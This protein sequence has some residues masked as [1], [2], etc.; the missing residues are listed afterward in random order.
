MADDGLQGFAIHAVPAAALE[1]HIQQQFL[2]H[3]APIPGHGHKRLV[4][5]QGALHAGMRTQI[6]LLYV[7]PEGFSSLSSQIVDFRNPVQIYAANSVSRE[8]C[9]GSPHTGGTG[10]SEEILYLH[11][12]GQPSVVEK[13]H[14]GQV[15]LLAVCDIPAI[16]HCPPAHGGMY[17][18]SVTQKFPDILRFPA[19]TYFPFSCKY[20]Y[21]EE[22][23]S[24]G[25]EKG[26]MIYESY[27]YRSPGR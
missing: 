8:K 3:T 25:A 27:R 26:E 14:A 22:N 12:L 2:V 7:R 5:F 19:H 23:A 24:F 15:S 18:S 6:V 1:L 4:F 17:F 13:V 21:R 20:C 16:P 10:P 9:P 11:H